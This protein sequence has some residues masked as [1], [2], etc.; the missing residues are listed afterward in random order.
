MLD[1]SLKLFQGELTFNDLINMDIEDFKDMIDTRSEQRKKSIE[2]Y[3]KT[4]ETDL[5]TNA[6]D[7]QETLMQLMASMMG[8]MPGFNPNNLPI[9]IKRQIKQDNSPQKGQ[10]QAEFLKNLR[11][12][13]NK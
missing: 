2:R 12:N 4:G 13:H 11:A 10:T 8:S 5:Y 1:A 7:S 6:S 9:H 3:N